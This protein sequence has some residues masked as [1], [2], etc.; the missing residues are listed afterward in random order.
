MAPQIEVR[1]RAVGMVEAGMTHSAVAKSVGVSQSSVKRW[2]R[3]HNKNESLQDKPRCGRPQKISGVIKHV[4]SKAIGKRGQSTRKLSARLTKK[5]YPV[6][7]ETVRRHMRHNL[8][9]HSYRRT[10]RPLLTAKMKKARIAFAKDKLSWTYED[11]K[12]ML[13]SDESFFEL[14]PTSNAAG[15]KVWAHCKEDVPAIVTVKH[16]PKIMVWGMFSHWALSD[17]HFVPPNT[18]VN[19]DY[20][21]EEIL[22]KTA[23]SAMSRTEENGSVTTRKMLEDTSTAIFMQDSAPPHVA[24]VNQVWLQ[25]NFP[26]YWRK[27]EWPR[28]SIP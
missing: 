10:K 9:L 22:A 8:G 28:N 5:G 7:R 17:L 23:A 4:I 14:F 15:D 19:K 21:R 12:R 26:S 18:S 27:G 1:A 20:Y 3:R 6:S 16:S 2:W 13:W 11:W 25:S 24:I